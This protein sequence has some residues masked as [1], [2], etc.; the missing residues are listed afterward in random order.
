VLR[1]Q[2]L[3]SGCQT[4]FENARLIAKRICSHP[5]ALDELNKEHDDSNNEQKMKQ[6][7]AKVADK[8]QRP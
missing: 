8:A 1:K 6:S 7:A 3:S 5:S 4:Y 2:E